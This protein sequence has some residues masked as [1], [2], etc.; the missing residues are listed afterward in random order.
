M[1][2]CWA[3]SNDLSA[4][5]IPTC[6]FDLH[7]PKDYLWWASFLCAYLP[8]VYL[9]QK[10]VYSS[11]CPFFNLVFVLSLLS[12]RS[13][14]YIL[15]ITHI[16]Y[17][18]CTY[19]LLFCKLT[20]YS[21]DCSHQCAKFLSLMKFYVSIFFYFVAGVFHV[22]S[23]KLLPNFMFWS[24]PPMVFFMN[25]RVLDLNFIS[26]TYFELLFVNSVN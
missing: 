19:I 13:F 24:C 10:N 15:D 26:S 3:L 9:H 4:F 6:G 2:S 16:K 20:F 12:C 1:N 17:M 11:L 23:K 25:F 14:L 22:I 8:F 7:I 18:V 21:V 5:L